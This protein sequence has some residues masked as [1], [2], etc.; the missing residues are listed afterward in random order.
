MYSIGEIRDRNTKEAELK[1]TIIIQK[2]PAWS[3][4]G[5]FILDRDTG[6]A[7]NKYFGAM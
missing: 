2:E 7:Q 5:R 3:Y 4:P 1:E 6:N